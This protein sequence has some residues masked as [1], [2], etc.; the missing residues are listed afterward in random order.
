VL[1]DRN[2]VLVG[3][4]GV[5]KSTVGVLLAK[6][7]SR[8]F[9]DTDVLIQQREGRRLQDIID[10]MGMEAFCRMEERYVLSLECVRTVIA[11]GGSVVYSD[12]AMAHLKSDGVAVLLDL[13][14]K[15]LRERLEDL[16]SRG[17]VMAPGQ[18]LEGLYRERRPL[19]MRYADV[20]IDCA[21]RRHEQVVRQIIT[22]L[23]GSAGR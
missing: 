18:T 20:T 9:V 16:D 17:I 7:L 8:A 12:R 5:G 21:G 19:Y 2:I 6:A 22:A 3:M 1:D 15:A 10:A 4:P 23:G 13:P 14:L 11:T